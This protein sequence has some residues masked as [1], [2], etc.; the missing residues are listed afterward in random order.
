MG[1]RAE[2]GNR[3]SLFLDT[4]LAYTSDKTDGYDEVQCGTLVLVSIMWGPQPHSLSQGH[5]KNVW[6]AHAEPGHKDI[7]T[8]TTPFPPTLHALTTTLLISTSNLHWKQPSNA[9]CKLMILFMMLCSILYTYLI[10]N[11]ENHILN[12]ISDMHSS[13]LGFH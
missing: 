11:L 9:N 10:L 2:G 5:D 13:P 3:A 4:Y 12:L 6:H 7:L 8:H 1:P